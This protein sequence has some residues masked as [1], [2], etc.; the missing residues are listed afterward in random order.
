M[1]IIIYIG[2]LSL[3]TIGGNDLKLIKSDINYFD[4]PKE[5][6]AKI[7]ENE[8][9]DLNEPVKF[10]IESKKTFLPWIYKTKLIR[11]KDNKSY[12]INFDKEYNSS[13][14]IILK[15]SLH[16]TNNYNVYKKDSLSYKFS[17]YLLK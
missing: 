3:I 7:F 10:K 9:C 17:K 8:F 13:T 6:K 12:K 5:V 2:I 11:L 15:D 16:T 4:L 1:K 14:L